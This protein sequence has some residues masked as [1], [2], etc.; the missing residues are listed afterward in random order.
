MLA[1]FPRERCPYPCGNYATAIAQIDEAVALADEK[2]ASFWKVQAILAQGMLFALTDKP[3]GAVQV[4]T[5][6]IT[7]L[8][9]T[10]ATV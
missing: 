10:G 6:D 7:A 8:Q 1:L 3:D 9:S 5:S 4:I 2:G